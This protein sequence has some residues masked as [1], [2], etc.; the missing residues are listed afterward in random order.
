MGGKKMARPPGPTDYRLL[1]TDYFPDWNRREPAITVFGVP[2]YEREKLFLE[3]LGHRA[4][5]AR[6]HRDAGDG[7]DRRDL[8]GRPREEDPIG[9]IE[10]L[11]RDLL[12]DH[13]VPRVAGQSQDGVASDPGQDGPGEGRGED[14]ASVDQ[15]EVLAAAFRDATGVVERDSLRVAVDDRLHL[16]QRG[17]QIVAGRLRHRRKRVGS[18]AVPGRNADVHS[19]LDRFFSQILTPLPDGDQNLHGAAERVDAQCAEAAVN[20]GPDVALLEAVGADRVEDRRLELLLR[21]GNLHPVDL[22]GIEHP[23]DVLTQTKGGGPFF[24]VR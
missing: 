19:L 14:L 24:V 2:P 23:L 17:V 8:G 9:D 16:D 3:A 21:V 18:H 1:T 15:E 11:P 5:L 4:A 22:A 7:A 12:L 10:Q 20:D 6:A 13:G